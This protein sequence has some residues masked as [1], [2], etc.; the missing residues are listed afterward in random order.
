[1]DQFINTIEDLI[2]WFFIL[3]AVLWA[4]LYWIIRRQ[5]MK[6][7]SDLASETADIDAMQTGVDAA[8]QQVKRN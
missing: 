4:W 3:G 5:Q 7:D 6:R 8:P 1:M 2:V